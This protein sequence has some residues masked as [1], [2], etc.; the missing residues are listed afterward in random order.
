MICSVKLKSRDVINKII[1]PNGRTMILPY[2][3]E[4]LLEHS[5]RYNNERNANSISFIIF[6]FMKN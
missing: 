6:F 3:F 2:V 5:I 4:K 1:L